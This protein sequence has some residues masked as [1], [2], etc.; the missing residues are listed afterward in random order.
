MSL[1]LWQRYRRSRRRE[2]VDSRRYLVRSTVLSH[3]DNPGLTHSMVPC[4]YQNA[5]PKQHLDLCLRFVTSDVRVQQ[6]DTQTDRPRYIRSKRQHRITFVQCSRNGSYH[7]MCVFAV[8]LTMLFMTRELPTVN[9]DSEVSEISIAT[10]TLGDASKVDMYKGIT[11]SCAISKLF[12]TVLLV[13]LGDCV[14][15][16]DL[17]FGCKKN[18]SF[19][20]AHWRRQGGQPPPPQLPGKKFC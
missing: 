18:S 6:T 8:I 2:L 7:C 12:E 14:K 17:Q 3:C 10:W 4:P 15:S 20:R 13:L 1:L 5:Q 19:S 9:K 11:L 16:D